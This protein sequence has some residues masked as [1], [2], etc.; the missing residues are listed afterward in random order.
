MNTETYSIKALRT[1][2][3]NDLTNDQIMI[4][5]L[6]GLSGEVGEICDYMKKC[7]FQGHEYDVEHI[8]EEVGDVLWY[9]NLLM[10]VTGLTFGEVMQYN[11]DKLLKRYPEGFSEEDS[12]N[13]EE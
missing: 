10:Y 5:A 9:V 1:A 12:I 2:R 4:N 8:K 7:Y 11:I 13:R 6:L 3:I